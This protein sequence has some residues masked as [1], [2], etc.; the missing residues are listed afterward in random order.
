MAR[1]PKVKLDHAEM[2]RLLNSAQ[3]R[4]PL[5]DVAQKAAERARRSAPVDT[6]DYRDGIR[7][8]SDNTDRAVERV[9]AHDWKSALIES[10][11]G[12]LKR[13]LRG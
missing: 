9:V 2:R 8:E 4:P 13:A 1:G 7:V 12:N 6:G 10:K 3:M 5:R 11:T